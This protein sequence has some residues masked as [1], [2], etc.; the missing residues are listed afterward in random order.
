MGKNRKK[1]RGDIEEK[2]RE[3]ETGIIKKVRW[4]KLK[5]GCRIKGENGW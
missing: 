1:R 3:G 4:C 5:E 2:K